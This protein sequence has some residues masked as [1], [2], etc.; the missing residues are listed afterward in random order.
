VLD[1]AGLGQAVAQAIRAY[2]ELRH[3]DVADYRMTPAELEAR[4][5][6]RQATLGERV[7]VLVDH[8]ADT[9]EGRPAPEEG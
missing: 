9:L 6:Q 5:Q 2:R 3:G 4:L 1:H 8:V 7:Q